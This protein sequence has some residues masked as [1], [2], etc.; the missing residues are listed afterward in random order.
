MRDQRV[1][2]K[3]YMWLLKWVTVVIRFACFQSSSVYLIDHGVTKT[4]I[5]WKLDLYKSND[6]FLKSPDL[7][8]IIV[9]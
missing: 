3:E 9:T 8:N 7:V 4:E 2:Y 5:E 1:K 6:T